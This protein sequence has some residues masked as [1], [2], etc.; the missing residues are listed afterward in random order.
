MQL[1]QAS[2]VRTPIHTTKGVRRRL[3]RSTIIPAEAATA[4]MFLAFTNF[5]VGVAQLPRVR[6]PF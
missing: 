5:E 2:Q 1:V 4:K 3:Q 6:L